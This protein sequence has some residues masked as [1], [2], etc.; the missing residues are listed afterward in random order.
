MSLIC[1]CEERLIDPNTKVILA[2]FGWL[3]EKKEY[4]KKYWVRIAPHSPEFFVREETAKFFYES[5]IVF[6]RSQ[7]AVNGA[8]GHNKRTATNG[9]KR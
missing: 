4:P 5:S 1:C 2:S 6:L 3:R 7:I 8:N 9:H